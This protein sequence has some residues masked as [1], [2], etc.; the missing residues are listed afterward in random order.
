MLDFD[1]RP[2]DYWKDQDMDYDIKNAKTGLRLN[3]AAADAMSNK[4]VLKL[5]DMRWLS[6]PE[7]YMIDI[8]EE[9]VL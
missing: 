4:A 9:D 3:K 6:R 5:F 7:T 8:P 1:N 2:S